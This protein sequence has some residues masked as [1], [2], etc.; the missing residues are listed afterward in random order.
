M[1]TQN[2]MDMFSWKEHKDLHFSE[3][4][5]PQKGICLQ[6]QKLPS[7]LSNNLYLTESKSPFE[8]LREVQGFFSAFGLQQLVVTFICDFLH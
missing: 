7:L 5:M 8:N 3:L 1:V 6:E 2:L 4:E